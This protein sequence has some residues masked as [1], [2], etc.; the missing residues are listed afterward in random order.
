MHYNTIRKVIDTTCPTKG[1]IVANSFSFILIIDI[2][3]K[4]NL[5]GKYYN[6]K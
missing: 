1:T 3:Y 5:C 4:G 2:K 6:F